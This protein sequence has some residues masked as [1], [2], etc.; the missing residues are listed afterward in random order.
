MFILDKIYVTGME[1]GLR[2]RQRGSDAFIVFGVLAWMP[3]D[4]QMNGDVSN[5]HAQWLSHWKSEQ[6]IVMS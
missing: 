4:A 3:A 2:Q 1:I 5:V 6:M